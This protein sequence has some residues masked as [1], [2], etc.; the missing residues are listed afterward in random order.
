[1]KMKLPEIAAYFHFRI[2]TFTAY[3]RLENL[4]SFDPSTG[5]FTRNN[6]VSPGYPYP[7]MVFRLGVYWSFIN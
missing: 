3:V 5:K 1:M 7:G 2:R 6:I 4:N